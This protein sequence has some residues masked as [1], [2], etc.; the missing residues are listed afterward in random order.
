MEKDYFGG[1]GSHPAKPES[2]P[3]KKAIGA[4]EHEGKQLTIHVAHKGGKIHSSIDKHD[5]LPA[6]EMTH[7]SPEDAAQAHVEAMKQEFGAE[8]EQKPMASKPA[9]S[10]AGDYMSKMREME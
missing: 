8:G 2:A 6:D 3:Q 10:A 4:K 9:H 1:L 5:G 7:D